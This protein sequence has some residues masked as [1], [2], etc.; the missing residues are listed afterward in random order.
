MTDKFVIKDED[1][2]SFIFRDKDGNVIQPS[3]K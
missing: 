1:K 3:K 2:P